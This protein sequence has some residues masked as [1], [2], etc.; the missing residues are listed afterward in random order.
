MLPPVGILTTDELGAVMDLVLEY[1]DI[2]IGPDMK[3]GFTHCPKHT[4]DIQGHRP[5]MVPNRRKSPA[6]KE[7]IATEVKKLEKEGQ[8]RFG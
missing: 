3:V 4:I 2:F 7:H 6:E 8:M 5:V 1:Q